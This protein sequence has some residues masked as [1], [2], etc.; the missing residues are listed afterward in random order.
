MTANV[1]TIAGFDPSG[2]AGVLADIKTFAA[3]RCYGVAAIS[4]LTAQNTQGVRALMPVAPDF[5]AAQIDA[6]F[7]DVE[8]AAVKIGMLGTRAN[9]ETVAQKLALYKPA[10]IVLDPVM[11]A[12]SG[13]ALATEDLADALVRH[14]A[15]LATLVTPNLAEAAQLARA[16]GPDSIDA[17]RAL[18][19][20]LGQAGFKAVLVK[21]GHLDGANAA[22]VLYDQGSFRIFAAPRV[23]T[24][25]A[26]GT[27]CT[28]S[29][30]IAA[31]LAN[32]RP[33]PDAIEAAKAYVTQGLMGADQLE[34]GQGPGPLHH[35]RDLW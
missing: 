15:P 20:K 5:L 17:M 21:G 28:L 16:A 4:A 34:V 23:A 10:A 11:R 31:G 3:L 22:D 1:L 27:G 12:S 25:N 8:I 33:L 14:L 26:H 19:A 13:D 24:K 30:A 9:I 29:S 35:F 2:G 6:L 18:G 32:G 7:A